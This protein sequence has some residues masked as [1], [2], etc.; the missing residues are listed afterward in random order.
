MSFTAPGVIDLYSGL[1]CLKKSTLAP[2][3][4]KDIRETELKKCDTLILH[5][6]L[7]WLFLSGRL[8]FRISTLCKH[9]E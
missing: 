6:P 4:E 2:N 3:M 1:Y 9:H 8:I 5:L 7:F